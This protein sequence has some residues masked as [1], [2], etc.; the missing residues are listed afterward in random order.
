MATSNKIPQ[1]QRTG[2]Y[3]S[4]HMAAAEKN[5]DQVG[6]ACGSHRTTVLKWRTGQR[7]M[8]IRKLP[9]IAK[10]LGRHIY[11]MYLPP[12]R[13]SL[14]AIAAKS[15]ATDDDAK[16]LAKMIESTLALRKR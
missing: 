10:F 6:G 13:P 16:H 15:G 4:E 8:D 1:W 9:A 11:E 7:D 3:L 2:V 12:G 14:D 5:D